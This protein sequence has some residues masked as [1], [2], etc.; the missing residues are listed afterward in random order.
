MIFNI[1]RHILRLS[2]ELFEFSHQ[3]NN[4]EHILKNVTSNSLVIIDELC[5]STNPKEGFQLAWN[6]CEHLASIRGV[7]NDGKYFVRDDNSSQHHTEQGDSNG[8]DTMRDGMVSTIKQT[9]IATRSS[10]WK[11]AQLNVVTAPFIFLT[12]HFHGLT[13]LSEPFFNVV[14]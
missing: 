14:K 8:S 1:L 5:R 9:S 11:N 6:L 10:S 7:L 3:M 13:K 2:S 4:M 12:T